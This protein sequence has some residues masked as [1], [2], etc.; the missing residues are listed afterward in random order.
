MMRLRAFGTELQLVKRIQPLPTPK[1]PISRSRLH[2]KLQSKHQIG[3]PAI[4]SAFGPGRRRTRDHE[5]CRAAL[6]N[7]RWPPAT[8]NATDA[9]D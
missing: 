5:V 6:G 1:P 8:T 2:R 4:L 7:K 3:Y 9:T